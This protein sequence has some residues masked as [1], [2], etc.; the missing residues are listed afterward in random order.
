LGLGLLVGGTTL[1]TLRSRGYA[2]PPGRKL[3]A[4]APWG[5][6]VVQHAAR[7]IVAADR[8]EDPNIPAADAVEVAG[9]VDAWIAR[10]PQKVRVDLGR[11]LAYLEQLAPL[12]SGHASRFT[13]LQP[14]AQDEVLA[15][16][17]ASSSD[18][19][20]AGFE[21]LKALVFSGYYSD[22]R[23]WGILGYD[24]PLVGRPATGWR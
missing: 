3:L 5:Y 20:R 2:L 17:E 13:R 6:V 10:M 1:V 24:G 15:A 18:L 19:L 11:F 8:P 7:R 21:G 23:T 12:A 14:L 9:F 4:L 22:A 16:V